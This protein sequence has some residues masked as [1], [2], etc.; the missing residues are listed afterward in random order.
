MLHG[1]LRGAD[2]RVRVVTFN[3]RHGQ[4]VGGVYSLSRTAAVISA[5]APDV[6]ALNEVYAWEPTFDQPR[7]L[8]RLTGLGYVFQANWR[9]GVL[10]YG[11]AIL[12]AHPLKAKRAVALPSRREPRGCLVAETVID[13][14]DI[15]MAATHLALGRATR[16]EQIAALV[17]ELPRDLPLV[18]A[19]DMNA[20][21]AELGPL[22]E[23]LGEVKEP[24]AT[25]PSLAPRV[26]YDH[27]L[28]SEE[29]QLTGA[30]AMR[31]LA[32]DHLPVY[33]DLVF[34]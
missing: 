2:A 32:S 34:K 9:L 17:R 4:G 19:G 21:S 25:Y 3:I 22:L 23:V 13:G 24:P 15:N 7:R 14:R 6:V 28:F 10:E 5:L 11:N 18:L 26:A 31:T 30:A 12:S 33:A 8:A 29:W 27:I 1:S 16:A 20:S